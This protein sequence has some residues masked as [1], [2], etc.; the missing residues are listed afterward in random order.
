MDEKA[1]FEGEIDNGSFGSPLGRKSRRDS[2][3]GTPSPRYSM[4]HVVGGDGAAAGGEGDESATSNN[5][6]SN[7]VLARHEY[8]PDYIL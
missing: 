8:V 4:E 5:L 3:K 1:N 2:A 6:Q 7:S